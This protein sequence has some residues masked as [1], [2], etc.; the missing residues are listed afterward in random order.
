MTE[1]NQK[2]R[3]RSRI[4]AMQAMYQWYLSHDELNVIEAQF[5]VENDGLK[6]DWPFFTALFHGV[7]EHLNR[8]DAAIR[9][10][11]SRDFAD[12]NPVELAI[13]RLGIYELAHRVD[14]PYQALINEY[15]ELAKQYGAEAGH[16][17]V[18]AV[19]DKQAKV[20]RETEVKA[21]N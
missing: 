11:I 12:V 16:Q 10:S 17:F 15:I 19:L 4:L 7:P 20:L 18:N 9:D 8:I 13:L 5:R 6:V 1:F 21:R 2:G 14:V 3:H